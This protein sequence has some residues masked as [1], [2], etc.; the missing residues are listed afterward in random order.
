MFRVLKPGGRVSVSDIVT[1]GPM[2]PLVAQGLEEWAAC[3]AGALD[4]KE[5]VR[6]LT[7][8]GFVDVR[9]RPKDGASKMLSSLPVGVPFSATITARKP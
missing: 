4:M 8:A 7:E 6:G 5:Y 9:V 2:S 3:V 1:H